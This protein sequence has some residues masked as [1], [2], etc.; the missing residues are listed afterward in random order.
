MGKGYVGKLYIRKV[1]EGLIL[2]LCEFILCERGI[3]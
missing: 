1:E 3:P 2:V